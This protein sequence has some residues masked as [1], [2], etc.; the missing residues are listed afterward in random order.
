MSS[1]E[2]SAIG[3][4]ALIILLL[5]GIPVAYALGIV[6][7]VGIYFLNGPIFLFATLET[8]PYGLASQYT[9]LV[10]PMFILMGAVCS[11]I[12]IIAE[13]YNA[14]HKFTARWKGG[15][16]IAT[17]FAS[18]GFAAISGSTVV[19]ASVFSR[20]AIPEMKKYGYNLGVA[21]GCVAAAGTLS[22]MIPPSL[23]MVLFGILTNESIGALLLAGLLPGLMTAVVYA[24]GVRGLVAI[25]PD[26][27]PAI[28]TGY[29][30]GDKFRSLGPVS[31][32]AILA[33]L[34]LGGIY[35][36]VVSP[37]A[38]GS[39]GAAGAIL[40]GL[41]RRRLGFIA[42]R[43]SLREALMISASL[44]LIIIAGL[45]FSRFLISTGL[46]REIAAFLDA[47]SIGK[48]EFM[49]IVVITYLV[50]GLFVDGVSVLVIT[51][52][53][54]YPVSKA[55]GIDPIWLGVVVVKLIE[56]AAITPPVGLNLFAVL[57]SLNGQIRSTELFKGVMPLV[58]LEFVTLALLIA[59]PV[60]STWLP[61]MML[62]R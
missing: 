51:L 37:S 57:G 13:L 59:F 45:L 61:G 17:V 30:W 20:I 53:V 31:Y 1:F 50:V 3:G 56:I 47:A 34:V 33:A 24:V 39:I 28:G 55:L 36:G 35:S 62:G 2:I 40:I 32:S 4:A 16:Y 18:A 9:F 23:A 21:G 12:G 46:V 52:P 29:S 15:L 7:A 54:L 8:L 60:I 14:A 48:W 11:R 38:A 49:A 41:A 43:E 19:A 44:F 42:M 27:A 6:A 22:A 58:L 5:L 25:R 26:L 10:V